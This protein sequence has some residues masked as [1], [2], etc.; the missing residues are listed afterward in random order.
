MASCSQESIRSALRRKVLDNDLVSSSSGIYEV[1]KSIWNSLGLP[2][3][4]EQLE[5]DIRW[6]VGVSIKPQVL[7]PRYLGLLCGLQPPVAFFCREALF[8]HSAWL[9]C[10]WSFSHA[11]HIM[12]GR[13]LTC[14]IY[15]NL[16]I[17]CSA[18]RIWLF[19]WVFHAPTRLF[20]FMGSWQCIYFIYLL[21]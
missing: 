10:S 4:S 7:W 8:L 16:I 9:C 15:S 14:V 5:L 20:F 3:C 18:H 19:T 6:S 21:Q 2:N 1:E 11:C 13:G 17:I 12:F